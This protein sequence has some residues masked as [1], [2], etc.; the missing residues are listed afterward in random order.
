M[1]LTKS[2]TLMQRLAHTTAFYSDSGTSLLMD[3]DLLEEFGFPNEI[4]V[5][6][7][8]GDTLNGDHS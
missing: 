8:A 5:T 3:P 4:T 2:E 1:N 6:V 7:E